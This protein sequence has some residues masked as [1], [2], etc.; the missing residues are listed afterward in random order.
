MSFFRSL[1]IACAP[2]IAVTSILAASSANAGRA[3]SGHIRGYQVNII[4]S[5]SRDRADYIE[6]FGPYGREQLVVT[7]APYD[8]NSNGPH[9]AE[10]VD[11]IARG[12]CFG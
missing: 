1:A 7:C 2:V 9:T 12:W 8:W 11:Y 5:G 4:D 6:I 3:T 10:F